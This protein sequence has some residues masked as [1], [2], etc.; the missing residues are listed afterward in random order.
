MSKT[1][2]WIPPAVHEIDARSFC[3]IERYPTGLQADQKHCDFNII[4]WFSVSVILQQVDSEEDALKC[5]MV[6]SLAWG[7]IVPSRRQT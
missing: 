7:L 1:Y 5:W 6:A 3:K 4:H 2:R